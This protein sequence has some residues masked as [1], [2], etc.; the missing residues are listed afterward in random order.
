M[1]IL[2]RNTRLGANGIAE[3]L[4]T[5]VSTDVVTI[6]SAADATIQLLGRAIAPRH[7]TLRPVQGGVRVECTARNRFSV[8]GASLGAATVALGQ[9]MDFAGHQL[10]AF[11]PPQGFDLALRLVPNAAASGSDY[12]AAFVTDLDRTRLSK[13]GTSYALVRLLLLLTLVLPLGSVYWHRAGGATPGLLP[14]DSWWSSGPLSPGH[15]HAAGARCAACHQQLFRHVQDTACVECHRSVQAH[16]SPAHRARTHLG[17]PER[18]GEC[19]REHDPRLWRAIVDDDALCVGCHAKPEPLFG[20]LQVARVEGFAAGRHPPFQVSLLGFSAGTW[21]T[22]RRALEGA[23]QHSN[24]KF[25]HVQHL[26]PAKVTRLASGGA[27]RCADCHVAN[28]D[29]RGFAPLT[30]QT[31][32]ASCHQLNFDSSAP[33]RQLPHGKPL[34]AMLVIEDYFT[35]KYADPAP[36]RTVQ[37]QR[38]LPDLERDPSRARDNE[39]CSGPPIACARQRARAEIEN[40][41]TGRGCVSCHVVEDTHAADLYER[42]QVVPVRL[43]QD[44]FREVR[45]SHKAHLIQ[46]TLRGDAAC[47]SCHHASGSRDSADL[48]LPNVDGCLQ[49]HR[50]RGGAGAPAGFAAASAAQGKPRTEVVVLQCTGCHVYHPAANSGGANGAELQ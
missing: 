40:Q 27:M 3:V 47:D 12:E 5:A 43:G 41:F 25:S 35:R 21:Q 46:G 18:C 38:R 45:F 48:L 8:E 1:D 49:C 29:G 6:G 24:L 36:L 37:P 17:D 28:P 10:V 34:D 2:I 22:Q 33:S 39:A 31:S 4:D 42:F 16:V 7:A 15:Q 13:R 23:T 50:D 26:D 20:E 11:P 44:Y 14:D 32:C 19:H 30:M 9:T